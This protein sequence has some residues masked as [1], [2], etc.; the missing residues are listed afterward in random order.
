MSDQ[1]VYDFSQLSKI[2]QTLTALQQRAES[3][4][5][6]TKRVMQEYQAKIHDTARTYP[7]PMPA[8]KY[9]RTYKLQNSWQIGE[10]EDAGTEM[11]ARVYSDGSART[12]Y[13]EYAQFVMHEKFQANIHRGR[14]QT[15]DMIAAE[16]EPQLALA[17][18]EMVKNVVAGYE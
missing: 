17:L 13:G 1:I 15:T 12:K 14:W 11:R 10:I 9:V 8:Q 3:V 7:P 2:S 16:Y 4:R 18:S 6:K 5:G